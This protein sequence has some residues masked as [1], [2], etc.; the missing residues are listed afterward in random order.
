MSRLPFSPE[1]E[2]IAFLM[3]L[4]Y[5]PNAEFYLQVIFNCRYFYC[6]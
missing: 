2:E 5:M 6:E 3:R 4:K 1:M